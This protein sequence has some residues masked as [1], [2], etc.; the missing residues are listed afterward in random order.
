ME[1]KGTKSFGSVS[2]VRL[3]YESKHLVGCK[4]TMILLCLNT[5]SLFIPSTFVSTRLSKQ[6]RVCKTRMIRWFEQRRRANR[7]A[8]RGFNIKIVYYLILTIGMYGLK[9]KVTAVML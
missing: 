3:F 8:L 5:L 2:M 7:S 6:D 4:K 1:N 9:P